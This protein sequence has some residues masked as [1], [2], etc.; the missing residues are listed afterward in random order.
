MLERAVPSPALPLKRV[1]HELVRKKGV[2]I[3]YKS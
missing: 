3:L 2:I 1:F